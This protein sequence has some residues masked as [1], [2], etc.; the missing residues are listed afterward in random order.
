MFPHLRLDALMHCLQE[1]SDIE[2]IDESEGEDMRAAFQKAAEDYVKDHYP[3][4]VFA[5]GCPPIYSST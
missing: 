1:V 3:A 2:A 4:G 5:V